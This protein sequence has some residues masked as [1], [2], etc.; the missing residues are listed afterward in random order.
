[1]HVDLKRYRTDHGVSTV[2]VGPAARTRMPVIIIEHKGVMLRQVAITEERYM[3][4]PIKLQPRKTMKGVAR[5]FRA[6]GTKL[7][8]SKPAKLFLRQIINA[9]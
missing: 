5:Q 1:M 7:G 9:D 3:S 8:I 2:L 6:I 4:E